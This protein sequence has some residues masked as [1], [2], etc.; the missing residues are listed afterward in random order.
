MDDI[1]VSQEGRPLQADLAAINPWIVTYN[2]AQVGD[3][4]RCNRTKSLAANQ[5]L[6]KAYHHCARSSQIS[7]HLRFLSSNTTYPVF[8]RLRSPPLILASLP[9]RT[10]VRGA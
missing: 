2:L 7:E 5:A 10:H 9:Y 3:H 6:Q 4:W 8:G 1:T